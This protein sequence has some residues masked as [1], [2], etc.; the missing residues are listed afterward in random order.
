[1][2]CAICGAI[3][4]NRSTC[5]FNPLSVNPKP[6][7]HNK[8]VASA[9][10]V[11]GASTSASASSS[12]SAS[13][14][15]SASG[16]A[17][18]SATVSSST[19]TKPVLKK[20][21]KSETICSLCGSVGVNSNMSTCPLNIL[22][23]N[24]SPKDHPLHKEIL[25]LLGRTL[26]RTLLYCHGNKFKKLKEL[27]IISSILEL[28]LVDNLTE[29]INVDPLALPTILSTDGDLPKQLHSKFQVVVNVNCD[30]TGG[31]VSDEEFKIYTIPMYHNMINSLNTNFKWALYDPRHIP[32]NIRKHMLYERS[33]SRLESIRTLI[34]DTLKSRKIKYHRYYDSD[35][36]DLIY[37]GFGQLA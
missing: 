22:T 2:S 8:S 14:S 10:S 13:A 15:T 1:M 37:Y 30:H 25:P 21:P 19:S 31:I 7:K 29:S 26:G 11:S 33:I 36:G 3:G 4:V 20:Q 35:S 9:N 24:L 23:E 18:T 17:S 28:N 12:A 27:E 6:T 34:E 5:P 32:I 16:S